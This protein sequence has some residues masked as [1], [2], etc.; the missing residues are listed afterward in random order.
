[1]IG[2]K[3][4]R[5]LRK[6]IGSEIELRMSTILKFKYYGI[7]CNV[8]KIQTGD[9]LRVSQV[10][11]KYRYP[12]YHNFFTTTNYADMLEISQV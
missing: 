7:P 1:M 4:Y 3:C 5:E 9:I 8:K 10:D 12:K 6:V 11:P 2:R